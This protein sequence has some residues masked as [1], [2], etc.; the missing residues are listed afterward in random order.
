MKSGF[1]PVLYWGGS[2]QH[3]AYLMV[4]VWG[5]EMNQVCACAFVCLTEVKLGAL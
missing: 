3:A 2:L 5:H 1:L 4:W